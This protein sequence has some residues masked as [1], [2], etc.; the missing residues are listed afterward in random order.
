VDVVDRRLVEER[1]LFEL[2]RRQPLCS[3]ARIATDPRG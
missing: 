3:L 1:K 2:Q